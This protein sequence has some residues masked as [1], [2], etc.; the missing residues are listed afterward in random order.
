MKN[1]LYGKVLIAIK[2][3]SVPN[4]KASLCKKFG[5][6]WQYKDYSNYIKVNGEKYDFT[7]SRHCSRC[8]QFAYFYKDWQTEERSVHDFDNHNLYS[9][10]IIIDSVLYS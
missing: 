7:A 6:R 1:I 2:N 3:I 4:F 5:H 8:N 9:K 10:N